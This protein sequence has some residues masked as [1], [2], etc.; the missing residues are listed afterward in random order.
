MR[1]FLILLLALSLFGCGTSPDAVNEAAETAARGSVPGDLTDWS[2][3]AAQVGDVEVGWVAAYG[4]ETLIALVEEAQSS[5]NNLIAA[6]ANVDRARALAEQAGAAFAPNLNL[7]AGANRGGPVE[8]SSSGNLNAGLQTSWELDLWGRIAS[9]RDASVNSLEAARAD[10]R[11]SQE[12]L[13]AGVVQ[14][15]FLLKEAVLQE[16]IAIERVEMVGEI[17]R[18]VNAQF[19]NGIGTQQDVSLAASDLAAARDSLA[20]SRASIRDAA[21]APSW[22][23]FRP[24]RTPP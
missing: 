6:A 20:V 7:T 3:I 5:N 11:F 15:Y 23:P 1:H 21:Y 19:E 18:I 10:Y 17:T 4:D 16:H 9:G 22:H 14:A 24:A 2:A 12:S 13:A 8:G